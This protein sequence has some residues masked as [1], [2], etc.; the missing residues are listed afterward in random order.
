MEEFTFGFEGTQS[1]FLV[2]CWVERE[3]NGGDWYSKI[4]I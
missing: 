3:E 1:H 2:D 4:L